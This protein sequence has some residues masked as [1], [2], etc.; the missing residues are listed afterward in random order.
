MNNA[1]DNYSGAGQT[2]CEVI[3]VKGEGGA[4]S[5]KIPPN[6]SCLAMDIDSPIVYLVMTDA[7]GFATV[8]AYAIERVP[9]ESEKQANK[10]DAV[11]NSIGALAQRID[12]IEKRLPVAYGKERVKHEPNA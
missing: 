6:S 1:Y 9:T 4:K 5:V 12:E 2:R 3:K 10:L 11:L 7:T 8:E